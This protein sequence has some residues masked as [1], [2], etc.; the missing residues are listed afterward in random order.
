MHNMYRD[1][2][3]R[4][5]EAP[6]WFDEVG[7]PRYEPFSPRLLNNIY[8]GE[9]ALAEISCQ[10]CGTRFLVALTERHV[11]QG[12]SLSDELWLGRAYY[13]DP[14]NVSCCSAGPTMGSETHSIFEYWKRDCDLD[15]DWQRDARFEGP[16]SDRRVIPSDTFAQ[17]LA[18]IAGCA[19]SIRV[20]CTSAQNRAH[21]AGRTAATLM[22]RT[23]VLV[24]FSM[25][26]GIAWHMLK[27]WASERDFGHPEQGRAISL[28]AF[29]RLKDVALEVAGKL[30]VLAP[31]ARP[32]AH[33][34]YEAIAE[35]IKEKFGDVQRIEFVKE[36][37]A[38]LID[39]PEIIIDVWQLLES[40]T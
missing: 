28:A 19:K 1:I 23:R 34:E 13:G 10:A 16:V 37:T 32:Q 24:T 36:G 18:A 3:E 20:I 29:D 9:A 39:Q 38:A 2:L 7:V 22:D 12:F 6:L 21:L 4:I 27:P 33:E 14:P 35:L 25:S 15:F 17:I 30:V 11:K 26:Q 5:P 31:S 40:S 8:S